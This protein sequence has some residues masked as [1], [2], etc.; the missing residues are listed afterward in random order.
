MNTF[1]YQPRRI[2]LEA[3]PELNVRKMEL[4]G[5]GPLVPR[6]DFVTFAGIRNFSLKV[7]SYRVMHV[8][9]CKV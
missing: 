9:R 7:V 3:N 4:R 6:Y 1:A 2:K 8:I 5:V